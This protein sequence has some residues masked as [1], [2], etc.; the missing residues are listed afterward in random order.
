MKNIKLKKTI[1]IILALATVFFVGALSACKDDS[2][3]EDT[4]TVNNNNQK[5][6]NTADNSA[7]GNEGFADTLNWDTAKPV[8]KVLSANVLGIWSSSKPEVVATAQSKMDTIVNYI[9]TVKPDSVAV[10]E[11]GNYNKKYLNTDTL[12]GYKMFESSNNGNMMPMFYRDIYSIADSGCISIQVRVGY[13]PVSFS[14]MVLE[15]ADGT[16]AYIHGNLHLDYGKA[17]TDEHKRVYQCELINA[18]LGKIFASNAEY[19]TIPLIL[20]GDYNTKVNDPD[21]DAIFGTL[22]GDYSIENVLDVAESAEKGHATYH[23]APGKL[24]TGDQPIDHALVN[25][26]SKRVLTHNIITDDDW[27][28]MLDASDHYPI[29]IEMTAK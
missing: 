2:N 29:L 24:P 16:L 23:S 9:N 25:S 8:Y 3:M 22:I 1:S 26:Q 17:G 6:E 15:N 11:Y 12:D 19:K 20:T 10:Q 18:E 13:N 4:D 5:P 7:T 27:D 28:G 21:A 14:W